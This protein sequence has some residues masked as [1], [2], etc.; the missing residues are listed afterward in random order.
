MAKKLTKFMFVLTIGRRNEY[1]LFRLIMREF[2]IQDDTGRREP[3]SVMTESHISLYYICV[4]FPR[5][6]WV[7]PKCV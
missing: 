1:R 6:L 4:L 3:R 2:L 7:A 5:D